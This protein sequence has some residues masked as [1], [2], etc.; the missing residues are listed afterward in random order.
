MSTPDKAKTSPATNA[1]QKTAAPNTPPPGGEASTENAQPQ[2]KDATV[3]STTLEQVTRPLA[4]VKTLDVQLFV[5][6]SAILVGWILARRFSRFAVKRKLLQ[7]LT[8]T[9][10]NLLVTTGMML[11]LGWL[12]LRRVLLALS[13]PFSTGALLVGLL[14]LVSIPLLA[15]DVLAGLTLGLRGQLAPGMRLKMHAHDGYIERVGLS[16]VTLLGDDG[17]RIVLPTRQLRQNPYEL[18]AADR[19]A[20]L[21]FTVPLKETPSQSHRDQLIEKIRWI[22]LVCP[23]R[24]PSSPITIQA[25]HDGP[26]SEREFLQI[27]LQ[28]SSEQASSLARSFIQQHIDRIEEVQ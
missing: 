23:Y 28:I 17:G 5:G 1:K 11:M 21:S 19:I 20:R 12:I 2:E 3:A 10:L 13:V 26:L 7:P 18:R 24:Q 8:G 22:C 25:Q 9:R 6:I 4:N 16:S 27:S 15:R 14:L